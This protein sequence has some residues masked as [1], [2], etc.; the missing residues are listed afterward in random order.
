MKGMYCTLVGYNEYFKIISVPVPVDGFF[1]VS[2]QNTE[3]YKYTLTIVDDIDLIHE[4]LGLL[5]NTKELK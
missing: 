1:E 5:K 4:D 3:T 2:L